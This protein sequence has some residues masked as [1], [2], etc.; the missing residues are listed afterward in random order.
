MSWWPADRP[1]GVAAD[2]QLG[3]RAGD[4]AQAREGGQ[5]EALGV[6]GGLAQRDVADPRPA[7]GQARAQRERPQGRAAA[8]GGPRELAQQQPGGGLERRQRPHRLGEAEGGA[9]RHRRA[10]R[11]RRAAGL[12]A[13]QAPG[14]Q[15]GEAQPVERRRGREGGDLAHRAQPE[16]VQRGHQVGG[17]GQPPGRQRG[18]ELRDL[19]GVDHERPA[20]R[21][22]AGGLE[23]GEQRRRRP[24]AAVGAHRQGGP[25]PAQDRRPARRAAAACRAR[26]RPPRRAPIGSTAKPSASSRS[27]M[28]LQRLGGRVGVGHHEVEPR[29]A[30]ERLAHPQAGPHPRG[31]GR[32]RAEPDHLG[33]PR[34]RPQGDGRVERAPG[35]EQRHQQR[36]AGDVDGD[37]HRTHVRPSERTSSRRR[38]DL[39]LLPQRTVRAEDPWDRPGHLRG[40]GA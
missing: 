7:V 40:R 15:A 39:A 19:V 11:P 30:R 23:G 6:G 24:D 10:A 14:A 27:R 29:A 2:P 20:P 32:R 35:L 36:E 17:Q 3:H 31:L 34:R 9:Q 33:R 4:L 22:L 37:D 13:R 25:H 12:A 28:P 21:R 5:G 8:A 38:R 18:Q 26:R 16:V 1:R